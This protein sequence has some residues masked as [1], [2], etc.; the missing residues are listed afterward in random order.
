MLTQG[1]TQVTNLP[2]MI[3]ITFNGAINDENVQVY[4]RLFHGEDYCLDLA[5][6]HHFRRA[7]EPQWLHRQ[8]NVLCVPQVHQLL[9]RPGAP[10][11]GQ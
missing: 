9:G 3:T 11:E 4:D 7:V 8:G 5:Y 10:Q 1:L 6:T 2:M